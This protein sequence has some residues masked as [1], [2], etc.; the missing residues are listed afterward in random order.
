MK[1]ADACTS[2]VHACEAGTDVGR[3]A[4][5]MKEHGIGAMPVVD[6]DRRV[7]AMITDRDICLATAARD[8]RPSEM[9]VGEAMS[10]EIHA[11]R[12]QDGLEVAL[13]V[14]GTYHVRRLPVTDDEDVLQ[15]VLSIDD[16]ARAA[17]ESLQPLL[18]RTFAEICRYERQQALPAPLNTPTA[19]EA[20]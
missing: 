19:T 4:R 5:T 9:R 10:G 1:I 3:V 18:L 2:P 11:C 7:I 20:A 16:I 14:M 6:R 17:D 12:P 13:R 15:G 8:L